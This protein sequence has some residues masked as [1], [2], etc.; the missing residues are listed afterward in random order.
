MPNA[1]ERAKQLID[2]LPENASL[3]DILYEL[4]V[5]QKIEQGIQASCEGRVRP[6]QEVFDGIAARHGWPG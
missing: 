1:K 4:Y 5:K 3:N 2:D 6:A